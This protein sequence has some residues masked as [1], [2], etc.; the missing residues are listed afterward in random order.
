MD[1]RSKNLPVHFH[2]IVEELLE[3]DGLNYVPRERST[4]GRV[5][6]HAAD[7]RVLIDHLLGLPDSHVSASSNDTLT[8]FVRLTTEP[9][10]M[11]S[12]DGKVEPATADRTGEETRLDARAMKDLGI[13]DANLLMQL[14]KAFL[15]LAM[16]SNGKADLY[17]HAYFWD[18]YLQRLQEVSNNADVKNTEL[19]EIDLY[20]EGAASRH[21]FVAR[22]QGLATTLSKVIVN[23]RKFPFTTASYERYVEEFADRN[24]MKKQS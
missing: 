5:F 7:S 14:N 12:K 16:K 1:T 9:V 21:P 23:V 19:G 15:H 18:K 24:S 10:K 17:F 20:G 13:K 11:P 6:E 3:H 2:E 22:L 8:F 4:D